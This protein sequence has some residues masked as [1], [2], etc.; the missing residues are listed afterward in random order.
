MMPPEQYSAYYKHF[1]APWN[2]SVM[3]AAAAAAATAATAAASSSQEV[4]TT[5]PDLTCIEV[6]S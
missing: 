3:A 1:N 6:I 5:L 2:A 4:R